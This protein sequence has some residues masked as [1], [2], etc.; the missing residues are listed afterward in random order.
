MVTFILNFCAPLKA[1]FDDC[2]SWLFYSA[3]CPGY[4]FV[5]TT[6]LIHPLNVQ[7]LYLDFT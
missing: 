4:S 3:V 2:P 7:T 5:L 1:L 6:V